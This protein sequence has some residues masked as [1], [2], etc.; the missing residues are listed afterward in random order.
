[1]KRLSTKMSN[2]KLVELLSLV[3]LLVSTTYKIVDIWKD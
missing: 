2:R 3:A 1:M